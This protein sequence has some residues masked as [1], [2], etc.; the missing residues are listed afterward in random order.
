MVIYLRSRI[1]ASC[2]S[3]NSSLHE[4]DPGGTNYFFPFGHIGKFPARAK[5]GR[6]VSQTVY[7]R[8][9]LIRFF[10]HSREAL[11]SDPGLHS[12]RV[13]QPDHVPEIVWLRWKSV[14]RT[15]MYNQGADTRTVQTQTGGKG[16]RLSSSEL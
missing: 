6:V 3:G 13:S 8:A 16:F 10:I 4:D 11:S 12:A 2:F 14:K 7:L 9:S 5:N 1:M 15:G